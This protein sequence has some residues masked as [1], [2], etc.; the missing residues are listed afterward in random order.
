MLLLLLLPLRLFL[1][2][3]GCC[4][5][6][7]RSARAAEREAEKETGQSCVSR[8][9][10]SCRRAPRTWIYGLSTARH[11][12]GLPAVRLTANSNLLNRWSVSAGAK[13]TASHSGE[14][15]L[16]VDPHVESNPDRILAFSARLFLSFLV[17]LSC[18]SSVSL[19][20]L[21]C[22]LQEG[23]WRLMGLTLT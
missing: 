8:R 12:H 4:L 14:S 22:S 20:L 21:L 19:M 6:G 13:A 16:S 1:L 3:V 5:P 7:S 2:S 11:L 18:Y 15:G 17:L 10:E 23:R 9:G